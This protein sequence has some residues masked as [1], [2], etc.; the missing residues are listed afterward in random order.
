[1]L[2]SLSNFFFIF[3]GVPSK[4]HNLVSSQKQCVFI[5]HSRFLL[6]H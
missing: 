6:L 3:P 2:G 1:M 4:K 5:V